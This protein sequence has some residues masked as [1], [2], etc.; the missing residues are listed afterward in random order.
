MGCDIHV[1]AEQRVD[2]KWQHVG[3]IDRWD[4][5]NEFEPLEERWYAMF[6][7]LAGVRDNWGVKPIAEPRRLPA[8]MSAEVFLAAD[9]LV[10]DGHT[11]SWITAREFKEYDWPSLP[12]HHLP[13]NPTFSEQVA[14]VVEAFE[15]IS[16][17]LDDVR[18]VFWFDN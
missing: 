15:Q 7:V 9:H 11:Y 2:G 13:I 17:N 8:D 14:Y 12:F 6:A 4:W 5:P 10:P 16:D 1:Y 18:I 3:G